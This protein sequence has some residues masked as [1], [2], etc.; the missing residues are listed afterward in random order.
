MQDYQAKLN[1]FSAFQQRESEA[2]LD[3]LQIHDRAL[4]AGSRSVQILS[5]ISCAICIQS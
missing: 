3:R 2:Q 4:L 5:D 1:P